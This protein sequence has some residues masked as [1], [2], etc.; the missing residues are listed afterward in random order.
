MHTL[1]PDT[2]GGCCPRPM[3]TLS[4]TTYLLGV[5]I[6]PI[7]I[8]SIPTI[9]TIVCVFIVCTIFEFLY[10]LMSEIWQSI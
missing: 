5:H 8:L 1:G 2:H 7:V 10:A 3:D 9:S 4:E 6:T